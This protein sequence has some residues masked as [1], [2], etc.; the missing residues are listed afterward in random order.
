MRFNN[1]RLQLVLRLIIL[2]LTVFALAKVGLDPAYRGTF[3]GLLLFLLLQVFLLVRFHERTN[4]QF[5]SF[6]N[7]IRHDDF[8][9]LI[10]ASTG[11]RLHRELAAGLNEVMKKFRAVRAEKEAHLHYFEA[12]VQHVGTGIITYKNDGSI[13][14]LNHAARK[15]LQVGALH[16]IQE[17]AALYPDLAVRLSGLDHGEKAVVPLRQGGSVTNLSVQ[18]IELVMLGDKVKLA[19]V[20]NIQR[21][22]EDKEMEAWQN[23]IKVLTHEIMNSV[24]PIASLSASAGEEISGY[25][26]DTNAEEITVLRD[27]LLDIRQCLHTISRRS[28]GLIHFVNDFRNL[29]RITVPELT[30]I[31]V[32]EL[33]SEI[34]TLLREQLIQQDIH[35]KIELRSG[36]SLLLSADRGMVEQVIINLVKNAMEAVQERAHKQITVRAYL[37]ERSRV[38]LE[39]EDNGQGMT[40]EATT[41]IFIPFFT[42]KK[43]GS[44][45]GLS[46]SR[47]IMRLHKGSISVQSELDRGTT[48][49]L[50]F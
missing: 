37:D 13:L 47:Q 11:G 22:L 20:Q 30:L 31:D 42:T 15:L 29:T 25:V 45:I 8:T 50:R 10:P 49:I 19:S 24:T 16:Q 7:S 14:L 41:K 1:Y 36:S 32:G 39:V 33:L 40:A 46:L 3:I 43:S 35:F 21:E 6:L 28:D 9:E 18:V 34:K 12:I 26:D 23:L 2:A 48:F 17:L 5:L 4:R 27:E 38:C 44:G